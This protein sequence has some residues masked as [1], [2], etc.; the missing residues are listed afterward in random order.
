MKS[1]SL[2]AFAFDDVHG[3]RAAVIVYESTRTNVLKY[4]QLRDLSKAEGRRFAEFLDEVKPTQ[5]A[6]LASAKRKGF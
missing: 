1:R 3:R 6:S 4:Q 5:D 2:A